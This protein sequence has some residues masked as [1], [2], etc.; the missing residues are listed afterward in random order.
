MQTLAFQPISAYLE[1]RMGPG[2]NIDFPRPRPVQRILEKTSS[3]FLIVS[4]LCLE[5][6]PQKL[7]TARN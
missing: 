3:L 5:Q 7:I 6:V 4:R 1:I 2:M